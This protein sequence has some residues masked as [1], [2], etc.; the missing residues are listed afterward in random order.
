M[1]R[2]EKG[3]SGSCKGSGSNWFV[4][5]VDISED[6]L[7]DKNNLINYTHNDDIVSSLFQVPNKAT[8][9]L[10]SINLIDVCERDISS[11]P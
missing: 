8:A 4:S 11:S 5:I 9:E 2:N 6:S 3:L 1:A 7:F 10:L